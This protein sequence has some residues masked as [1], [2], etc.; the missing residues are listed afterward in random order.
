ML[1][2][3]RAEPSRAEPIDIVAYLI[4]IVKSSFFKLYMKII[5]YFLRNHKWFL[6]NC[7]FYFEKCWT[8]GT[9][10]GMVFGLERGEN[11]EHT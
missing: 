6:G 5:S 9:D 10:C 1:L 7:H 3:S 8:C 4:V 2:P 11:H